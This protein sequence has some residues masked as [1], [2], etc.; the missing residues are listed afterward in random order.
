MAILDGQNSVASHTSHAISNELANHSI[1]VGR[2]GG[3]LCSLR[4]NAA[5]Q[6][7]RSGYLLNFRI[8]DLLGNRAQLLHNSI[9]GQLNATA[10]IIGVET[11]GNNLET[12]SGDGTG[13]N[14]GAT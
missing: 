8:G 7:R 2:D 14:R 9:D 10:E 6:T 4:R 12:L 11:G 3:N 13:Q 5:V 1:A